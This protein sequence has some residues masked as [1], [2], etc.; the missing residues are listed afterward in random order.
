MSGLAAVI[1]TSRD[2]PVT[3]DEIDGL[4]A[5]YAGLR[6][7]GQR[8]DEQADG[9]VRL[10]K[11]DTRHPHRPGIESRD[12]SW[13]ATT[14]AALGP[15]SL[16]GVDVARL[17]GQFSLFAYDAEGERIEFAV[18]HFG[19]DALYVAERPHRVFV[20]NC[21]LA[22]AKHLGASP[23][24]FGVASFVTSGYHFGKLTNW[25]GIERMDPA[26]RWIIADHRVQKTRYWRPEV[27]ES[28]RSLSFDKTVDHCIDSVT[29]TL[30]RLLTDTPA[31]W[32]DLTGGY[33]SRLMNLLLQRAGVRFGT[34]T[35]DTPTVED[36]EIARRLAELQ[37]WE[38]RHTKLPTDWHERVGDEIP[39]ALA[40]AD[41]NLEVLQLSRVLWPHSLLA[42]SRPI[43]FSAGGG[44][45]FQYAAWKSEFL[46]AGRS[47]RV[48]FD[49]FIDMRML[50]PVNRAMFAKDWAPEIKEDFRRRLAQHVAPYSDAPN[51]VQ[52]DL[53]YA[54]KSMGHF[55][56]Y[57]ASDSAYL[58]AQVPF[59]Y[60]DVF[61]TAF[62]TNFRYRNNHRL[63]R[64]MMQRLDPRL[65]SQA[66]S[67][68]G[69][70]EPWRPSNV[71]RF[72]PYYAQ[73]GR[74]AVNKISHKVTGRTFL[75]APPPTWLWEDKANNAVLDRLG[76]EEPLEHATMRSAALFDPGVLD[77][78][79]AAAR[80][81]G[82]TQTPMLGRIL[83][84]ELA[85]RATDS[86]L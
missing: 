10:V 9:R 78:F 59:Y 14:G 77:D 44:E 73:I 55:G 29:A 48:H 80:S 82:F 69:P 75:A 70:A 36:I 57:A 81:S 6:G 37:G 23:D 38:W 17:D 28:V 31:A 27:D 63:V 79:L 51:T 64:H 86:A 34:T 60:K 66:T 26:E 30:R 53:I 39:T 76:R 22:L 52:L 3:Q 72:L 46:R 50:K 35:R 83:T 11:I 24:P 42:E 61:S 68:G 19:F 58:V 49:N 7:A 40:W 67:R 2:H 41:A 12:G 65:A 18:D 32:S 25:L 16:V 71:H 8:Y 13:V 43:L 62:S 21:A 85:L 74:K 45:H 47:N 15:T 20:S 5:A 1:S 54:Y 33:D 56:A 84:I 4:A